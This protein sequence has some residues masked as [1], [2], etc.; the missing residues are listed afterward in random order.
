MAS[1]GD[2]SDRFR[3]WVNHAAGVVYRKYRTLHVA[4]YH[5]TSPYSKRR[6]SCVV[7]L[8]TWS[9]LQAPS[10]LRGKCNIQFDSLTFHDLVNQAFG[11]CGR[12]LV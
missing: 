6:V 1:E 2:P 11:L 10:L 4:T 12:D 8:G 9:T 7:H 3:H 5:P